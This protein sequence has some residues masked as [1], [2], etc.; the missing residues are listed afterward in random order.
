MK[1]KSHVILCLILLFVFPQIIK[2]EIINVPGDQPA[3]QAGITA[4]SAG[5]T[6]LV[7]P[8]TYY[9]NINFTGKNIAVASLFLTT[10][11]TAYISQTIINGNNRYNGQK[12]GC[13]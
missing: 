8:G 11:D 7:Q 9:E 6:V 5:D 3:I 2:S 13:F 10:G 12:G 1:I 4:S